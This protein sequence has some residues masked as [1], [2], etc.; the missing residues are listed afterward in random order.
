MSRYVLRFGASP[1]HHYPAAVHLARRLPGY[2]TSG[3]DGPREHCVPV[4]RTHLP[5]IARLLALV[6]GWKHTRLTVGRTT[7]D[8]QHT[9][10]LVQV[11][12]CHRD[13]GHSGLGELYCWGLPGAPRGR[14][15]CRRLDRVLPWPLPP[16][17]AAPEWRPRLLRALARAHLLDACPAYRPAA[18]GRALDPTA[19]AGPDPERARLA[20]LLRDVNLDGP[21]PDAAAEA[22][23]D[24]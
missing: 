23:P 2:R 19:G 21:A 16:E 22:G 8:V 11:L 13:R 18:M 15:P 4:T 20:R 24:A 7:L 17:Y 12:A 9:W 10:T 14:L 6:E 5:Q 3:G 1:S